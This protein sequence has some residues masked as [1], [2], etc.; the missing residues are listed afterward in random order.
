MQMKKIFLIQFHVF[1]SDSELT[2]RNII[3]I[4]NKK[5]YFNSKVSKQ[6]VCLFRWSEVSK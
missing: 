4:A 3:F 1:C 5:D 6:N 2:A